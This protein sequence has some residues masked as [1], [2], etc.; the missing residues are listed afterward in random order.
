MNSDSQNS[1]SPWMVI[2]FLVVIV[3]VVFLIFMIFWPPNDPKGPKDSI[4][5]ETAEDS[6]AAEKTPEEYGVTL[7][8]SL[9]TDYKPVEGKVDE[10]VMT[11]GA[12]LEAEPKEEKGTRKA[13]LESLRP[14]MHDKSNFSSSDW[15][16]GK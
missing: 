2:A 8:H 10:E 14:K 12:T 7:T 13:K 4:P 16:T 1:V 15:S 11:S 9:T 3:I 5:K 6:K